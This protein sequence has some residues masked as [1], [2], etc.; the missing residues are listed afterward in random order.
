M[1]VEGVDSKNGS[2]LAFASSNLRR[3]FGA[4][5]AFVLSCPSL[6]YAAQL[7]DLTE[8]DKTPVG[9]TQH[10]VFI[11][12]APQHRHEVESADSADGPW[13]IDAVVTATTTQKR[14]AFY[15]MILLQ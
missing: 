8:G 14:L 9:E 12:D 11:R 2:R 7:G 15:R 10:S 4:L 5:A 13:T 6:S 3:L 1:V